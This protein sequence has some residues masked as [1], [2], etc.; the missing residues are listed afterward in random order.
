MLWVDDYLE[1]GSRISFTICANV[2][3]SRHDFTM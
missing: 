2:L 3:E 1:D